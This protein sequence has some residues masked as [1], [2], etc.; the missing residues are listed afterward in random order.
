MAVVEDAY[1]KEPSRVG[2]EV[3]NRAKQEVKKRAKKAAKDKVKQMAQKKTIQTSVKAVIS[4]VKW[5]C[6]VLAGVIAELIVPIICLAMVTILIV[7]LFGAV[8]SVNQYKQENPELVRLFLQENYEKFEARVNE[9]VHSPEFISF[10]CESEFDNGYT[11][12]VYGGTPAYTQAELQGNFIGVQGQKAS[13][14]KAY[15]KDGNEITNREDV[16]KE[17]K[18]SDGGKKKKYEDVTY[19]GTSVLETVQ[20]YIDSGVPLDKIKINDEYLKGYGKASGYLKKNRDEDK[21]NVD[22][23]EDLKGTLNFET[24]INN[25]YFVIPYYYHWAMA[26][27]SEYEGPAKYYFPFEADEVPGLPNWRTDTGSG[28]R[29]F[30]LPASSDGKKATSGGFGPSEN[31]MFYGTHTKDKGYEKMTYKQY[32][33]TNWG[34]FYSDSDSD[35]VTNYFWQGKAEDDMDA[36]GKVYFSQGVML[37]YKM[38]KIDSWFES[39][40]NLA[41]DH[42]D[43][44]YRYTPISKYFYVTGTEDTQFTSY[45]VDDIYL[46][47]W[48]NKKSKDGKKTNY[49][50][51]MM[52]P[53]NVNTVGKREKK[54]GQSILNTNIESWLD[55]FAEYF[56]KEIYYVYP[57]REY[58]MDFFLSDDNSK[59]MKQKRI[60]FLQR[61]F[62]A[63]ATG[64]SLDYELEEEYTIS[65]GQAGSL[66]SG[67]LC[68]EININKLSIKEISPFQYKDNYTGT[69]E[70][71]TEAEIEACKQASL[72]MYNNPT[73]TFGRPQDDTFTAKV[74]YKAEIKAQ[75]SDDTADVYFNVPIRNELSI[76]SDGDIVS[77]NITFNV[78]GID[79]MTK[80][81]GK[82]SYLKSLVKFSWDKE[83]YDGQ[84]VSKDEGKTK[85]ENPLDKIDVDKSYKLNSSKDTKWDDLSILS[86]KTSEV[87][88]KILNYIKSKETNPLFV[89]FDGTLKG[90]RTLELSY[91]DHSFL[92]YEVNEK[93]DDAGNITSVVIEIYTYYPDISK[94]GDSDY[95]VAY[96]F[97]NSDA[98]REAVHLLTYIRDNKDKQIGGSKEGKKLTGLNDAVDFSKLIIGIDDKSY[99]DTGGVFSDG[100]I[101]MS[102]ATILAKVESGNWGDAHG[103]RCGGEVTMTVGAYQF[104]GERAHR[105]LRRIVENHKDEALGII[106]D[107]L[108][109][110]I[111]SKSDWVKTQYVAPES[112]CVML[113]KLLK[114]DYGI[115]EQKNQMAEDASVYVKQAIALG[116]TDIK[117]QVYYAVMYHQSP[118][119]TGIIISSLQKGFTLDELHKATLN[120]GVLGDYISRYTTTYEFCQEMKDMMDL[121]GVSGDLTAVMQYLSSKYVIGKPYGRGGDISN[122]A[123]KYKS[124]Y[125]CSELVYCAYYY[126]MGFDF[127]GNTISDGQEK[128]LADNNYPVVDGVSNT[129][130]GNSVIDTSKLKPGDVIFFNTGASSNT[131]HAHNIGHVAVYYGDGKVVEAGSP[132]GYYN[133]VGR[134]I[135]KAYRIVTED[136]SKKEEKKTKKKQE[137]TTKENSKSKKKK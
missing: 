41:I 23:N 21:D 20:K 31:C 6:T 44:N 17:I 8:F 85:P 61:S 83:Y 108:Y 116:I 91:N 123:Q 30:M 84:V 38:E 81:S 62:Y 78:S 25:S 63:M 129:G 54:N 52:T 11:K 49:E 4:A 46:Y 98:L 24:W 92:N 50:K 13:W 1:D 12:L 14:V 133:V 110:T 94:Y 45:G 95:R 64:S 57:N 97:E 65:G 130:T 36:L 7:N 117:C 131:S 26:K 2:N 99:V 112:D 111:K 60:A 66:M 100:D 86:L 70:V 109:K 102:I 73:S 75:Y 89:L 68:G 69:K 87:K 59:E 22:I 118:K 3:K 135:Y 96:G 72:D 42:S 28:W 29:R 115:H 137:E 34:T 136:K 119:Q 71:K 47:N 76:D 126:G 79:D 114:T 56:A 90:E 132:V 67:S 101:C 80:G 53:K 48:W 103:P 134:K 51:Y 16:R 10:V 43:Q 9:Y 27:H 106:S 5:I 125:D 18:D 77:S 32:L 37:G 15:D 58:V 74:Y 19:K 120:N 88:G 105:L 121:K 104:Y 124:T 33:K 127:G 40:W 122:K 107:S 55:N 113:R 39:F 35:P 93:K 82:N 128:Y